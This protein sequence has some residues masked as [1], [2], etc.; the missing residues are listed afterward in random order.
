MPRRTDLIGEV[1]PLVIHWLPQGNA[2]FKGN[3]VMNCSHKIYGLVTQ[4]ERHDWLIPWV[5]HQAVFDREMQSLVLQWKNPWHLNYNTEKKMN[6]LF[7]W[8]I[9]ALAVCT[10]CM[11]YL[12]QAL[13]RI[14]TTN[15]SLRMLHTHTECRWTTDSASSQPVIN[16]KPPQSD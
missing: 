5:H 13:W 14:T 16:T 11:L 6:F 4:A 7:K 12:K 2:G 1:W 8:C 9:C 3:I 10:L 15:S